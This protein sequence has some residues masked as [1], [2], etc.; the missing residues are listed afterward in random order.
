MD[1]VKIGKFIGELRREKQLTQEDL[2]EIMGVTSKSIS[3]WENGKTM[4]DISLLKPLCDIL[5]ISINELFS[6]E[7]I[8]DEDFLKKA[9]ENIVNTLDFTKDKIKHRERT[10]LKLMFTLFFVIF[11]FLVILVIVI[12]GNRNFD[13][14]RD[15]LY[16]GYAIGDDRQ[17]LLT[18]D[19]PYCEG[20]KCKGLGDSLMM[21]EL[22]LG[23]FIKNLEYLEDL[24]DGGS[25]LYYYNKTKRVF[26]FN[27]FYVAI[28][29]S[30]DGIKDIFISQ[31]KDN[32]NDKCILKYNDIEGISMSIKEGSLT[33]VSADIII[34]DLSKRD[35][36]YGADFYLQ[37]KSNDEWI[38]VPVLVQENGIPVGFNAIG[39]TPNQNGE[40]FFS[41]N[42]ESIYGKL[43]TG[44]YRLIK[45]SA[46]PGE[47]T[48]H[49]I[50][51]DFFL[52]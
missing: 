31:K 28:C 33:S 23:D 26:V 24:K 7:R 15:D 32:L 13:S 4:P 52:E 10:I 37:Q 40:L 18:L 38:N 41:I 25:I 20:L 43:P 34:T 36:M 39:Y 49:F 3:R 22:S 29:N 16:V 44:E 46:I 45:S 8:D 48:K 30:R 47:G 42:W 11:V 12:Q 2:A 17:L 21:E 50:T 1:Q 6:G 5:G 51:V 9:E 35:N 14:S 19:V 27:N